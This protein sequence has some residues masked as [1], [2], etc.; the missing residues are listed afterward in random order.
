MFN[1]AGSGHLSQPLMSGS[2]P[3]PRQGKGTSKQARVAT[4]RG[5]GTSAKVASGK[6]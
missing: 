6:E 2:L 3:C 1:Q 4:V 5:L